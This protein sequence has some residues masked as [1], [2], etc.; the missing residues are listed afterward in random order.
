MVR[1]LMAMTVL[2]AALGGGPAY[3]RVHFPIMH[4]LG[5]GLSRGL[6]RLGRG[7]RRAVHPHHHYVRHYHRRYH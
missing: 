1:V 3:A 5:H 6:H 4:R 2:L 7:L